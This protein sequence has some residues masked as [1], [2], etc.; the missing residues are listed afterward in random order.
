MNISAGG[1]SLR[2][3]KLGK[4]DWCNR[5]HLHDQDL[6]SHSSL[7]TYMSMCIGVIAAHSI[8]EVEHMSALHV[9]DTSCMFHGHE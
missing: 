3:C 2:R 5:M 9:H 8:Q 1:M 7:D 6:I 4:H